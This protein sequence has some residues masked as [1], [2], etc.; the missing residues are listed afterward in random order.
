M[1]PHNIT[2]L[3]D[4]QVTVSPKFIEAKKANQSEKAEKLLSM[5]RAKETLKN[6]Y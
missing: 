2:L 6:K 4:Q 5:D 1:L 3:K